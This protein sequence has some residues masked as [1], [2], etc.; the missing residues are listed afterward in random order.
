A[1]L[2]FDITAGRNDLFVFQSGLP[3]AP[4]APP[5]QLPVSVYTPPPASPIVGAGPPDQK[6]AF[7]L[8]L[9]LRNVAG[10]QAAIAAASDPKSPTYRQYVDA[11]TFAATYAPT[12]ADTAQFTSWAQSNGLSAFTYP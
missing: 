1:Y 9:P 2:G 6:I 12:T 7:N 11:G 8:V 10:L 4:P 5:G 3:P